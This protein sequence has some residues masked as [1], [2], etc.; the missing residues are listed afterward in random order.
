MLPAALKTCGLASS[1]LGSDP[2]PQ[3]TVSGHLRRDVLT[4]APDPQLP[5][6]GSMN[7]DLLLNCENGFGFDYR[8]LPE[9]CGLH[10]R[11]AR[12]AVDDFGA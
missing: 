8:V 2:V 6:G 9:I 1:K 12:L 10:L 11:R 7:K 5:R 4:E 3:S